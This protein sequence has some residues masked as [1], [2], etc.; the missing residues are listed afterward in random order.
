MLMVLAAPLLTGSPAVGQSYSPAVVI[1]RADS[2][3]RATVGTRLHQYF[4]YD[5]HS[6]YAYRNRHGGH[7]LKPLNE[8]RR[9]RERFVEGHVQLTFQHPQYAWIQ[10]G[11][12]VTL[13]SLL[14]VTRLTPL[15]FLPAFLVEDRPCDFISREQA[16]AIAQQQGLKPGMEPLTAA[17]QYQGPEEGYNW[18]VNN[19]ISKEQGARAGQLETVRIDALSG[20]VVFH[21]TGPYGNAS[22]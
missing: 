5:A 8:R 12:T 17:L 3:L 13:D 18:L 19:V 4:A 9:T 15:S 21:V 10:G 2:A 14:R 11:V 16:L 22:Y 1:A 6:W 20:K 7:H